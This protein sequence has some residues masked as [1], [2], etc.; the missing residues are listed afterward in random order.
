M[1]SIKGWMALVFFLALAGRMMLLVYFSSVRGIEPLE[2]SP[3][4]IE[5]EVLANAL[6]G[7]WDWSSGYF[8][9]RPPLMPLL[10]AGVYTVFGPNRVAVAIT[11]ALLGA[12]TAVLA[13]TAARKLHLPRSTSIL[14]GVLVAFDPASIV[15]NINLQAESLA[16]L[17]L[18]LAVV[19]LTELLH[20]QRLRDAILAG[21]W[22]GLATLTRP[23]TLY[24]F[25]FALPFFVFFIRPWPTR[26]L[27]FAAIPALVFAGWSL[28]NQRF[29]GTFTYSTVS[30]FNMLFYRA[31]SV[32]HWATHTSDDAV[33]RN[34]ALE[35]ERRLG[36]DVAASEIDSGFFWRNF[37]PADGRRIPIMR[38]MAL[39]TFARHPGWYFAL[40][41]PGLYRMYAYTS[42]YGTPFW[43]E[44]LYNAVL[45]L[46]AALGVA[47]SIRS[48][49][50]PLA[51]ITMMMIGYVTVATLVSQ[52]TGMD[53]RMRT[54]MT[55][56]LALL[57][58]VGVA[59][60][61]QLLARTRLR[62]PCRYL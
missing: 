36:N 11:N 7:G 26:Y 62:A 24:L 61:Q 51:S 1:P 45:Y 43:P 2:L 31:V 13:V 52:T 17:W 30:D 18:A 3:D 39:E 19:A 20:R 49:W 9:A 34:F 46:L 4:A 44:L 53:T 28:R 48:R 38:S 6:L 37:S 16:N 40:I 33:R 50:L 8:A 32:E 60:G 59:W 25:V 55:V 58:A 22:V 56:S 47:R 41:P 10:F 27:A 12:A 42:Q 15:N 14:A 5:Y 21:L 23:T 57:A 54:S 35:V 29:I